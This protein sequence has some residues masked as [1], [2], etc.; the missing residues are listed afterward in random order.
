MSKSS[1]NGTPV[2]LESG[3]KVLSNY[4]LIKQSLHD[5]IS[6][7]ELAFY[8][9]RSS[10]ICALENAISAAR[11]E[12]RQRILKQNLEM[13]KRETLFSMVSLKKFKTDNRDSLESWDD[14]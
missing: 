2:D 14:L 13:L 11:N 9:K 4:S 3:S 5:S 12:L 7:D 6:S 8:R 10:I 1:G